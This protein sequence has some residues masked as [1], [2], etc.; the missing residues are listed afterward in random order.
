MLIEKIQ[1]DLNESIKQRND[2]K[3]ETL[4]F[5]RAALQNAAIEKRKKDLTDE[6]VIQVLKRLSKQRQESIESFKK[7]NR[8]DL[9]KKEEEELAILSKYLPEGL[10]E[11]EIIELIRK[12]IEETEAQGPKDMG[13]V[14]K[15]VMAKAKGKADGKLVSRLVSKELAKRNL[16]EKK[17]KEFSS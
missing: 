17:E 7:G 11:K 2:I 4:R 8:P 10:P 13:K 6:E 5:V 1:N 9:V 16:N 12:A 3:R 14:M 15:S